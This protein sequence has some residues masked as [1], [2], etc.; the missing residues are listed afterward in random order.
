M[1]FHLFL[2]KGLA[3]SG[4][5]N[6]LHNLFNL[7]VSPASLLVKKKVLKPGMAICRVLQAV[8]LY[9]N[10]LS[11]NIWRK[12]LLSLWDITITS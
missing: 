4:R 8:A 5:L 6:T 3:L 11:A 10:S 12:E 2:A 1:T 9:C 7:T